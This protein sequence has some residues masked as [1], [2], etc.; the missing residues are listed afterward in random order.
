MKFFVDPLPLRAKIYI[1]AVVLTGIPLIAVCL[2]HALLHP[3]LNWILLAAVAAWG[4]YFP[5]VIPLV[6]GKKESLSVTVSDVFIFAA[7]LLYGPEIAVVVGLCEG[8]TTNFRAKVKHAYKQLFNTSQLALVAFAVGSGFYFF[9][10][11]TAPLDPNHILDVPLLMVKV[12]AAGLAYFVLNTPMVAVAISSV[13]RQPLLDVWKHNFVWASLTHVA[14]ACLGGLVFVYFGRFELYGLA[15]ASPIILLLYYAYKMNRERISRTQQHLDEVNQLLEKKIVAEKA[16]QKAKEELETR[17]EERTNELA[18]EKERLTVTLRSIGDGVITTDT[19]GKISLLNQ[20]AE[21]LTGWG[22]V[23]AAGQPLRGVFRLINGKTLQP[24]DDPVAQVLKEGVVLSLDAEEM[25]IVSNDGIRR[26][27]SL[28]GTPIR[29]QRGTTLGVVLVFRDIT[30][31]LSMEEELLKGQKLESLGILAGGIA[32]DFNNILTGIVLKTQ[33]ARRNSARGDDPSQYFT[34]IEEATQLATTLTHQLL[35]FAK[36]GAPITKSASIRQL[37]EES[38]RFVLRGS[39]IKCNCLIEDD[40][41]IAEIDPGQINQVINNLVINAEQAM[42]RGGTITLLAGNVQ[43]TSENRVGE[44]AAGRYV[45]ISVEDEGIGIPPENLPRI[46]DPYFTTKPE[47]HGLGL[48]GTYSII[49]RHGGYISVE[50][51]VD[52]GTIFTFYVPASENPVV[53]I[54]EARPLPN[55]EELGPVGNGRILVMDDEEMIREALG[56]L[57]KE[58]GYDVAFAK[59]GV[60][61]IATYREA[62][63]QDLGFDVVIMDLTIPGGMGGKEAIQELLV[64]D[65]TVK[66]IVSSGYSSDPVMARYEDYGFSAV[67]TKPLMLDDVIQVLEKLRWL[68][69]DPPISKIPKDPN[70]PSSHQIASL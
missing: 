43:M 18:E 32:H 48:A 6:K 34:S 1:V 42:P 47:G 39:K 44:L 17:V 5:V 46:F 36:G 14:G 10:G 29:D 31:Q 59:D 21:E 64:V 55:T 13:T 12:G 4:S 52:A 9:E 56:E 70:L 66:A 68:R 54:E 30:D 58:L 28:T 69:K 40:L 65:P 20:V 57:L 7:I 3:D 16:L 25:T 22:Q 35:T 33:L 26:R 27:I 24:C 63:G 23:K 60:E 19:S 15:I 2:T 49:H 50:S 45:K 67:L 53:E 37:L 11:K 51:E 61:A 62:L 8:V 41:W 38:T